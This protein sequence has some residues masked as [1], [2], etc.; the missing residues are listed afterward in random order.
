MALTTRQEKGSKLTIEEMD[1]NLLYLESLSGNTG[2]TQAKIGTDTDYSLFD[3]DGSLRFHGSA[4]TFTDHTV[5][6]LTEVASN[7]KP[8]SAR[9]FRNS[10]NQGLN[11]AQDFYTNNFFQYGS[12]DVSGYT[13][14]VS[15]ITNGVFSISFWIKP[16]LLGGFNAAFSISNSANTGAVFAIGTVGNYVTVYTNNAFNNSQIQL[17]SGS[18]YHV[19][20]AQT[21]G[22]GKLY[23][24]NIGTI[25][26]TIALSNIYNVGY[27]GC[28][29]VDGF[30]FN[31]V[32]GSLSNLRMYNI[33]LID[34]QV[35]EL[36]NL[37]LGLSVDF[38][39][40]GVIE[41][42]D[43]IFNFK[44]LESGG[45]FISNSATLG[46][47][48]DIELVLSPDFINGPIGQGSNGVFLPAFELP[49]PG[50]LGSQRSI[51]FEMSHDWKTGSA[52]YLHM[53]IST[54]VDIIAGQSINFTL[55]S[56]MQDIYGILSTIS[57]NILNNDRQYPT[58]TVSTF[59]FTPSQT[60]P[61]YSNLILEFGAIPMSQF[62]TT[63]TSGFMTIRRD[64]GT[65]TGDIF[66]VQS[67]RMHYEID[68]TGSRTLYLK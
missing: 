26:G 42:T 30:I 27:W 36:F 54:N 44:N 7:G 6:M 46:V 43:V 16:E 11:Y 53:H 18:W 67:I 60:V 35:S 3:T 20:Y 55:E 56:S 38:Q 22:F 51:R 31:T 2:F 65:F 57:L 10:G 25:M 1:N 62:S 9:M 34:S 58:T 33:E 48:K 40:S 21:N 15:A 47:G 13:S 32:N 4:T 45:T 63:S 52:I 8:L 12:F 37:G 14:L 23:V 39:P 49:S 64:S 50:T 61:A 17:N 29:Y 68:S 5:D 41:S 24:N 28:G 59:T 19:C 66:E